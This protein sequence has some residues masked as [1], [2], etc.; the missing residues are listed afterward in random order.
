[1][2]IWEECAFCFYQVKFFYKYL[3]LVSLCF[4]S[5]LLFPCNLLP[6]D[7]TYYWK[8]GMKIFLSLNFTCL[9][10]Y[11]LLFAFCILGLFVTYIQVYNYCVFLKYW[12]LITIMYHSLGLVI[13]FWL[14]IF[15][16][17]FLEPFRL[18]WHFIVNLF[19]LFMFTL[20]VFLNL[21]GG[22]FVAYSWV[23]F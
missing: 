19:P 14:S 17:I 23:T 3:L 18:S 8:Q 12:P 1:M 15:C 13:F 21:K 7:S 5:T 20:F 6:S 11:M 2:C 10:S 16:M 9:P 4:S 22:F